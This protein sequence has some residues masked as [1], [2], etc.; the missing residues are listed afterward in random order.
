MV[1]WTGTTELTASLLLVPEDPV[2]ILV[3]QGKKSANLF[4]HLCCI[5]RWRSYLGQFPSE[6]IKTGPVFGTFH[7]SLRAQK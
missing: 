4:L 7:L 5:I 6:V 1:K 2:Q 3:G